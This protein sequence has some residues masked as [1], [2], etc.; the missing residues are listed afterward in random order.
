MAVR[1]VAANSFLVGGYP[2][3]GAKPGIRLVRDDEAVLTDRGVVVVTESPSFLVS[4]AGGSLVYAVNET[5]PGRVSAFRRTGTRAEPGLQAL[6]DQ[7]T[8]GAHP[9]HLALH[10]VAPLVA[11]ANYSSGSVAILPLAEDGS[12]RPHSQLLQPGRQPRH[13]LLFDQQLYIANQGSNTVAVVP[14]DSETGLPPGPARTV[15]VPSPSCVLRW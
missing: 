11:V 13:V 14:V 10:P 7:P 15:P 8:G 1:T 12:L 5:D 9:C 6:G 3:E 2:A 4:S